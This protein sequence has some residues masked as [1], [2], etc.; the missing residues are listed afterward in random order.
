MKR[1]V[2]LAVGALALVPMPALADGQADALVKRFLSVYD[3]A[4]HYEGV[5]TV[6]CRYGGKTSETT[7]QLFLEK[8]NR[9]SFQVLK[10]PAKPNTVGTK[11]VWT[12]GQ[13]V[14]LKTR[15]FGLPIALST[16]PTDPRLADL[17]GDTMVDLNVVAAVEVLRSPDA[18][19]K[20]LGRR[21]VGDRR[22]DLVEL[23]SPRLL[24]GVE[25]E[26]YGL[27]TVSGLPLVRE[28]HDADGLT[29]K[30]TVERFKLDNDLPANA[31][32]LD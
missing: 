6:F 4:H 8:P 30:L 29:Y 22:V 16:E 27:D 15:F 31:F 1:M 17:R 14:N 21:L 23:R 25:R 19:F 20:Y 28:M 7:Y 26:V 18:R 13:K 12:S 9:S 24:K 32:T 10:A 3:G 11:L 5:V 2:L